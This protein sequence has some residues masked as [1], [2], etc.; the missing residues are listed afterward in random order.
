MRGP[1]LR[2]GPQALIKRYDPEG[3]VG[4]RQSGIQRLKASATSGP[5]A[6]ALTW[7]A[8]YRDHLLSTLDEILPGRPETEQ[9]T[10]ANLFTARVRA[11]ANGACLTAARPPGARGSIVSNRARPDGHSNFV[12]ERYDATGFDRAC[13]V[14]RVAAWAD[15][16]SSRNPRIGGSSLFRLRFTGRM[17]TFGPIVLQES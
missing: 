11:R 3:A 7:H 16:G 5:M 6:A 1:C 12:E 10:S 2:Q 4:R 8:V 13:S 15:R 14:S 17:G 9:V